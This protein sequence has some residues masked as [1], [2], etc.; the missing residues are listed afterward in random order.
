MPKINKTKRK[1][2]NKWSYKI[3]LTI[4]GI[5]MLYYNTLDQLEYKIINN[6]F[7]LERRHEKEIYNNIDTALQLIN[8]LKTSDKHEFQKRV[9]RKLISIYTNNK[10][11][12]KDLADAMDYCTYHRFEPSDDIPLLDNNKVA[13]KKLPHDK[14]RYKIYLLPHKLPRDEKSLY[15][16]WLESQPDTISITESVKKWFIS[17]DWNWDRRYIWV[18]DERT[19]L[20]LKLRNPEVC[21]KVLEYVTVDK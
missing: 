6:I 16:N 1:F 2:Y 9:E 12:Y 10:D 17:T 19:L 14:F 20:M 5:S 18:T 4:P 8:I 21:G 13:C 11:L 7:N 15:L 3:T